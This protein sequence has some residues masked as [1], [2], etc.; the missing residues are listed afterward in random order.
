MRP[1]ICG[2]NR[3]TENTEIGFSVLG[4]ADWPSVL[5]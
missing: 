4:G 2:D 5:C 1:G 3:L